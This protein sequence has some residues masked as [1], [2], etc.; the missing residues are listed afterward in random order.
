VREVTGRQEMPSSNYVVAVCFVPLIATPWRS[1]EAGSPG[2]VNL[3]YSVVESE[4]R[5]EKAN[6]ESDGDSS[7]RF[8]WDFVIGPVLALLP[9]R[10]RD[11]V[12]TREVAW[13]RAGT[14]SGLYE[15]LG[16][17]IAL[18][19][20]YL[21]EMD[22]LVGAGVEAW[23]SGR[24]GEGVTEHQIGATALTLLALHPVTWLLFYFFFEGLV[25]LCSAAFTENTLGSLP[26]YLSE[27][28]L[29]WAWHPEQAR[30]GQTVR[31]K[32]A[33]FVG[34]I[35]ERAREVTH[36]ELPDEVIDRR[37]GADEIVEIRASRR[38]Q[39]W[40]PPRVVRVGEVY[41]RLEQ[42]WTSKG[43]R[44]FRYQ[45]RRLAAGVP[46]RTVIVYQRPEEE[47]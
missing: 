38:K 24:L 30:V 17:V 20:W 23:E 43:E 41:Y 44:P 22:R 16:A 40:D 45:L 28:L 34:A 12:V 4:E 18:V 29:F 33:S 42:S 1:Q 25:R 11:R 36:K 32:A 47:K 37:D 8:V 9:K 35:R 14:T 13:R 10:S 7:L 6:F 15:A 39:D 46:G 19:G 5:S 26:L 2:S 27:R 31:D 3:V 21:F